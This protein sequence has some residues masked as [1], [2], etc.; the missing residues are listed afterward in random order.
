MG[1]RFPLLGVLVIN[2]EGVY[3]RDIANIKLKHGMREQ[4]F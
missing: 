2:G 4:V 1:V 3:T